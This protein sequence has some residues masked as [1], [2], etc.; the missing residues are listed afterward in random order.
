MPG[1]SL[2]KTIIQFTG[3]ALLAISL[4]ACNDHSN[5]NNT[6]LDPDPDPAEKP[7]ATLSVEDALGATDAIS[8]TFSRPMDKESIV[9][10][11]SLA[12]AGVMSWTTDDELK[13]KP[14]GY[15][16]PGEQTLEIDAADPE[17]I[18]M[19]TL[20]VSLIVDPAFVTGQQ[21]AIVIGQQDFNSGHS[22]QDPDA[23]ASGPNTLDF[24]SSPVDYSEEL[25]L[26]FIAD[27]FDSRVLG[28]HGIP[29]HNN[30]NADFV[31]GQE[32]FHSSSG[33]TSQDK[34]RQPQGI[35]A[36]AGKLL[37]GDADS[38]RVMIYKPIP[39]TGPGIAIAV[40]GQ[41][42]FESVEN[43]CGP[44]DLNHSHDHFVTPS[45]KLLV[46]D[47]VNNRVL[48]WNTIPE[49]TGVAPDLVIGQSGFNNCAA[50][51]DNQ[52]GS[53]DAQP[54]AR[55]LQHPVGVWSD[56]ERLVIADNYNNRVLVW[57]KFPEQ[58]REPADIVLGQDGM[59]AF[60]ANDD[61]Q[62]GSSDA[63]AS[64]RVLDYPWS[65]WVENEQLF[66]A[67]QNNNRVLVWDEWP[68]ASFAAADHVIGQKHFADV[69]P[70]GGN[71]TPG[72]GTLN[73]PKGVRIVDD[74]LLI[75]DTGNSRVLVFD[76]R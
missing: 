34:M 44:L 41:P 6:Q 42:D 72:A 70:N 45:G 48:V 7:T 26:L 75:T 67:D 8:V 15:W 19:D 49:E 29:A 16:P 32:D 37:V 28:F 2:R 43:G 24:P 60:T 47:G 76:A 35:R 5:A 10:E 62:D 65:V 3:A 51:D 27:T 36:Q 54:S 17:G 63:T 74:K 53:P 56:D 39:Q 46:A 71:D 23:L 13:L 22:R 20:A 52:D 9:L 57:N 58:G 11:G 55:T 25:D 18:A 73:G 69:S 12:D 38:H 14:A 21:A 66:V 61:D 31:L 59:N 64:A 68:E 30:A 33:E 40:I 50:N 1:S 4:S